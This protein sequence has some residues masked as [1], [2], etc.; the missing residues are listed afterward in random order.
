M[1]EIIRYVVSG[2]VQIASNLYVC[3][4]SQ[5]Q[6]NDAAMASMATM[7]CSRAHFLSPYK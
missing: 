4:L 3:M 6:M 7:V 1:R 2:Q 5:V